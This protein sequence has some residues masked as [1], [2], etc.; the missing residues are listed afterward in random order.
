MKSK[1]LKLIR[2]NNEFVYIA[3]YNE[4][5][6]KTKKGLCYEESLLKNLI[7]Y[8]IADIFGTC[9]AYKL[10]NKNREKREQRLLLNQ[11]NKAVSNK[12]IKK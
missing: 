10:Y 6:M 1:L 5:F 4:W 2:K 12:K 9:Y 8:A 7:I 3:K 11:F